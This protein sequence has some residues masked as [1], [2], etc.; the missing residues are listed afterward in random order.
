M[1]MKITNGHLTVFHSQASMY[2][3]GVARDQVHTE[4]TFCCVE[5]EHKIHKT[6]TSIGVS[7]K[8]TQ[9]QECYNM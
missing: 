7:E 5:A 2:N 9:T 4:I 8:F 3:N 1:C 6:L